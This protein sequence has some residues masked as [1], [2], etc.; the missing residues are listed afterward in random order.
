MV[1]AVSR[2]TKVHLP[3][4]RHVHFMLWLSSTHSSDC[5]IF[6]FFC[7]FAKLTY[8]ALGMT[9][10]RVESSRIAVCNS[11][12][13]SIA[14][15]NNFIW[16]K[17]Q[18][19]HKVCKSLVSGKISTSFFRCF[20]SSSTSSS[21]L[22]CDIETRNCTF[23]QSS[24]RSRRLYRAIW[25]IIY[26]VWFKTDGPTHTHTQFKTMRSNKKKLASKKQTKKKWSDKK[27]SD[28]NSGNSERI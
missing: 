15:K 26:S 23:M 4:H 6:I 11:W 14:D 24:L 25:D 7:S 21:S 27:V 28:E 12:M 13:C 5:L 10:S 16:P 9:P 1:R 18:T 17:Q 2:E 20:S 19:V 22:Y 3:H 8:W